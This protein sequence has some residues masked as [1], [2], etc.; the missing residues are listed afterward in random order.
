MMLL[1]EQVSGRCAIS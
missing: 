1:H